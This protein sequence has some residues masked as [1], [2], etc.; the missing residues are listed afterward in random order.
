MS[1]LAK[2]L[3]VLTLIGAPA[4]GTAFAADASLP[5]QPLYGIDLAIEK[6][7]EALAVSPA[8]EARLGLRLAEERAAEL[9]KMAE[10][11]VTPSEEDILRFEAQVRY[12]L[13]SAARVDVPQMLQF[14]N[15]IQTMAQQQAGRM[16]EA[17][18]AAGFAVMEQ[19]ITQAQRGLEDPTGFK[20]DFEDGP[21]YG[22][23]GVPGSGAGEGGSVDS[24]GQHGDM[25]QDCDPALETCDPAMDQ[26]RIQA[27]DGA[28]DGDCDPETEE[29]GVEPQ[30]G[31]GDQYGQPDDAGTPGPHGTGG[32]GRP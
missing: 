6:V 1:T 24:P 5:G 27:Q 15:Q 26:D 30:D 18:F 4:T 12:A 9:S 3:L 13:Q 31:T 22:G 25:L 8:A 10:K 20:A 7:Q 2:A 14:L 17:G 16:E 28:G 21:G 29:C 19:A 11:G 23:E 32:A